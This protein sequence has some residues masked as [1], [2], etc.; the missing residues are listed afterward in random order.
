MTRSLFDWAPPDGVRI[1][2]AIKLDYTDEFRRNHHSATFAAVCDRCGTTT[3][4]RAARS[5]ALDDL[6]G[7]PCRATTVESVS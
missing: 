6:D 4:P 7:H 3:A 1:I 2:Q 5:D